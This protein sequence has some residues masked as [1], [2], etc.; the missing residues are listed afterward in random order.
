MPSFEQRM[1]ALTHN[2]ELLEHLV[3][4]G[5]QALHES[6]DNLLRI[7]QLHEDRLERLEKDEL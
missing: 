4:D 6:I 1:E 5:F 7:A 3:H 2:L